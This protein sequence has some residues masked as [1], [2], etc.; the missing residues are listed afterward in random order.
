M[1][2]VKVAFPIRN[3]EVSKLDQA[4]SGL[5]L[6]GAPILMALGTLFWENG[7][8]GARAGTFQ[9]Y[10][11]ALWIPALLALFALTKSQMPRLAT[12]GTWLAFIVCLAGAGW[13]YDGM[14]LTAFSKAGAD[15]AMVNAAV[16]SMPVAQVLTLQLPGLFFPLILVLAGFSI[17]RSN[18]FPAWVP[19]LIALGGIGFPLSRIPRIQLLA[20]TADLLL[21]VPLLYIGWHFVRRSSASRLAKTATRQSAQKI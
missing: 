10:A 20:H 17:W 12:L 5:A 16:G 19:L 1:R 18:L 9:F 3:I 6:I 14:Y 15:V 7:Q 8:V 4:L 13:A 2:A 11:M 21:L